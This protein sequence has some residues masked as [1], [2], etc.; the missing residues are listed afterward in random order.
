MKGLPKGSEKIVISSLEDVVK[1]INECND[2]SAYFFNKLIKQNKRSLF[3]G[4]LGVG[5]SALAIRNNKK[6]A[7]EIDRLKE[8]VKDIEKSSEV[9]KPFEYDFG[10]DDDLK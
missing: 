3:I 4:L 2:I 6:N 7:D 5:M 8:K 1:W 9:D 10:D